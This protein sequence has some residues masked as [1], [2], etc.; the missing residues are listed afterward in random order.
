MAFGLARLACG[1]LAVAALTGCETAKNDFVPPPPPTVT[2]AK[3]LEQG[4]VNYFE[5]TGN[6]RSVRRVELRAR[7][8][9]Y[10]QQIEFKDG[11][12]VNE[13]DLLFVIDKAP[14][15]AELASAQADLEKNEAQLK[16][17][18]A[19]LARTRALVQRNAATTDQLDIAEAERAS[20]A[21]DVAAA[22]AAIRKAELDLSFTE[23]HAP[24]AGRIGEHQ[25]D[26]GNLV[27]EG[28]TLLA[29]LES[30]DP[31]YA[32]FYLSEADLLRF[33]GLQQNGDLTIS[34]ADPPVIELAIGESGDFAFTG[35]LDFREF[36][37]D[38][39]TGTT[40]R[41]AVF[42]ND[43]QRLVPGLF[44]RVRAA[45][46]EA[47]P[48]LLVEE[49]A[50]GSDQ[51]GD[52]LLV[53]NEKNV[54]EYRPVELGRSDA[55]LRVIESGLQADDWVVVNGLQRARPGAPVTPEQAQMA[56]TIT[57][58]PTAFRLTPI[59]ATMAKRADPPAE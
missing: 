31:I 1:L 48:R 17:A 59:G 38:P 46:G 36:G 26:I 49:R 19:Q 37:V 27:Q 51:R 21:A 8:G 11:D 40:L 23:I 41:R 39:S 34:D 25:V 42:E 44:V 45:I 47:Q 35:R 6:T 24:F 20:A 7:V 56:E 30:V 53:V 18:T 12:L 16:L 13:G 55:G 15:E 10:L 58:Q 54:V 32:Y 50:I 5:T 28:T 3:P 43:E 52:Y 14:F 9:G 57:Q 2:V 29:T 33:L 22:K 4:V